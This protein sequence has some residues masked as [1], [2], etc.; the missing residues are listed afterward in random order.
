MY[1]PQTQAAQAAQGIQAQGAR[2]LEVDSD[3][4]QRA[5]MSGDA[6]E[7]SIFRRLMGDQEQVA[8]SLYADQ[9][10][11]RVA[12]R[13]GE[14]AY[15]LHNAVAD[16]KRLLNIKAAS[17]KP[18][19]SVNKLMP[20]IKRIAKGISSHR[21]AVERLLDIRSAA[22]KSI[23]TKQSEEAVKACQTLRDEIEYLSGL[24]EYF[25][26][27][28]VIGP[29]LRDGLLTRSMS[30]HNVALDVTDSI[31][32]MRQILQKGLTTASI[33]AAI[34]E[35]SSAA[36][37]SEL[38]DAE[39]KAIKVQINRLAEMKT[40]SENGFSRLSA[41]VFK[42]TAELQLDNLVKQCETGLSLSLTKSGNV[43]DERVSDN[44]DLSLALAHTRKHRIE[45]LEASQVKTGTPSALSRVEILTARERY[46]DEVA[47]TIGR[48]IRENKFQMH[49]LTTFDTIDSLM[50]QYSM[51]RAV[52]KL[53]AGSTFTASLPTRFTQDESSRQAVYAVMS[54][55]RGTGGKVMLRVARKNLSETGQQVIFDIPSDAVVKAIASDAK[56]AGK[57]DVTIRAEFTK[58]LED[59]IH[60]VLRSTSK[61]ISSN[62]DRV[63]ADG[64]PEALIKQMS[65]VLLESDRKLYSAKIREGIKSLAASLTGTP[66][67]VAGLA[68]NT[69]L[70]ENNKLQA[71]LRMLSAASNLA[72]MQTEFLTAVKGAFGITGES[73]NRP[74]RVQE[75]NQIETAALSREEQA[76]VTNLMATDESDLTDE[77]TPILRSA[78]ESL[79]ICAVGQNTAR[80]VERLYEKGAYESRL[81][82]LMIPVPSPGILGL[83]N[84]LTV[85]PPKRSMSNVQ[86]EIVRSGVYGTNAGTMISKPVLGILRSVVLATTA[87]ALIPVMKMTANLLSVEFAKRVWSVAGPTT[88][89]V[90]GTKTTVGISRSQRVTVERICEEVILS[91]FIDP[92]VKG[93]DDMDTARKMLDAYRATSAVSSSSKI[94]CIKSESETDSRA[95]EAAAANSVLAL[96]HALVDGACEAVRARETVMKLY[97]AAPC[98]AILLSPMDF[99]QKDKLLFD[100][101]V[102]PADHALGSM[103]AGLYNE[104]MGAG[105][106]SSKT[107]ITD[108]FAL[109]SKSADRLGAVF[110]VFHDFYVELEQETKL[111]GGVPGAV[112]KRIIRRHGLQGTASAKDLTEIAAALGV[113]SVPKNIKELY[114][115]AS[116]AFEKIEREIEAVSDSSDKNPFFKIISEAVTARAGNNPLDICKRLDADKEYQEYLDSVSEFIES[117]DVIS[118]EEADE[119]LKE[120]PLKTLNFGAPQLVQEVAGRVADSLMNTY[121]AESANSTKGAKS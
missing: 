77:I 80:Q 57:N 81:V 9:D 89:T 96:R 30:M 52:P 59:S 69:S 53:T 38:T 58:L 27:C 41:N 22:E 120:N 119:V 90:M 11:L 46:D 43:R 28:D 97:R 65:R 47:T 113:N 74:D 111:S 3:R 86:R 23:V 15:T 76:K 16:K 84:V 85:Q 66:L 6:A 17:K 40:S 39:K 99:K 102:P 42:Q 5:G 24:V 67:E 103:T 10:V 32:Q 101:L 34:A 26:L 12:V 107:G 61:F 14:T 112:I 78:I 31:A 2:S 35:K 108:E 71:T 104:I 115:A 87:H 114:P 116:A 118:A 51:G 105:V 49:P 72:N 121:K 37:G 48:M 79:A 98:T 8:T 62:A 82:G 91:I 33:D 68:S 88:Y 56:I 73:D 55:K 100:I 1:D 95:L 109:I 60:E 70:D 64:K 93:D 106:S 7:E 45:R 20:E 18:M 54:S 75:F 92:L 83:G 19:S 4:F 63:S 25:A 21:Q 117:V 94:I 110:K 36:A 29:D 50:R 44:S 13:V